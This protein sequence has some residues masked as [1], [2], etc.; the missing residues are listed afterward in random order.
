[1]SETLSYIDNYFNGSLSAEEKS[2]FEN[3]CA[4]DP[5]FAKEVAFYIAAR[6]ELKAVV[7]D[8]K[9]QEFDTLYRNLS[10]SGNVSNGGSV[11]RMMPWAVSAGACLL[12]FL[13][14]QLFFTSPSPQKMA[15]RYID[16]NLQTL[17]VTMGSGS[18]DSLQAGIAAYNNKEYPKAE[19]TF[20]NLIQKNDSVAS[21]AVRCLGI[22]YLV[23]ERYDEA[24][25]QFDLLAADD[26]L[27][28]NPAL[29]YKAVTLLKRSQEGDRDKA[30]A[31][32]EEVVSKNLSGS[33][34]AAQWL[35]DL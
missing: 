27:Y 11:R 15:N 20:T 4:S 34:E 28:A 31:L 2:S 18:R 35:K 30:K 7:A 23:T 13:G 1:M 33:K 21:E 22:V 14:W 3:R 17:G 32:L 26:R 10:A 5:A 16:D 9:K 6:D 12:L 24:I 25:Q 29:F 8:Q 19:M